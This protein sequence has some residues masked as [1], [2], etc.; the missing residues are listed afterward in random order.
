MK[1]AKQ[2]EEARAAAT[3]KID[4]HVM[5]MKPG[6]ETYYPPQIQAGKHLVKT[7][8]LLKRA[9]LVPAEKLNYWI[10]PKAEAWDGTMVGGRTMDS[11]RALVNRPS[12]DK[13]IQDLLD[14]LTDLV[15][16]HG[17]EGDLFSSVA[18]GKAHAAIVKATN[19]E[20]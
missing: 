3:V 2:K 19:K 20:A 10:K 7:G 15:G 18:M 13:I 11:L 9:G 5:R 12:K 8:P 4:V 6:D 14:A 17:K 16:G 1:I